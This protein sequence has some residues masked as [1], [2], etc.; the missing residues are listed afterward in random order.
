[1]I[2]HNETICHFLLKNLCR[3]CHFLL[4]INPACAPKYYQFCKQWYSII[5]KLFP[6][7]KSII[8]K[9]RKVVHANIDYNEKR[10]INRKKSLG[11]QEKKERR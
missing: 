7:K 2:K 5:G 9:I 1:M 8:K 6:T 10:K 11:N 3:K 4:Q